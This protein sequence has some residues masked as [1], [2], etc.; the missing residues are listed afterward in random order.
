[1]EL[2]T[3]S[4]WLYAHDFCGLEVRGNPPGIK[5][6]RKRWPSGKYF[7]IGNYRVWLGI[8]KWILWDHVT[9]YAG[10]Q[11]P[12]PNKVHEFVHCVSRRNG[13]GLSELEVEKAE[14]QAIE[15]LLSLK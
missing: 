10:A 11:Y 2:D 14:M 12:W 4:A 9:L 3:A 5:Y 6:V 13:L 8:G 15:D 7:A 1:M